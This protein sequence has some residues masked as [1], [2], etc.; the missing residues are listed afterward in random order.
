MY[1][2]TDYKTS[3]T[4]TMTGLS[5]KIHGIITHYT[6][7]VLKHIWNILCFLAGFFSRN[8]LVDLTLLISLCLELLNPEIYNKIFSDIF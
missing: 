4:Q 5:K 7:T 6:E 8:D 1:S 2:V 3:Y